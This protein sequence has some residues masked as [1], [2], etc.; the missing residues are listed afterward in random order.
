[1]HEHGGKVE[2]EG[3]A[4]SRSHILIMLVCCL[5][6]LVLLVALAYTGI[7]RA[8]LSFAIVLLCPLMMLLMYLPRLFPR[9]KDLA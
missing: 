1:M 8:A 4:H 6:P 9:K 7:D 2:S 5:I 3:A